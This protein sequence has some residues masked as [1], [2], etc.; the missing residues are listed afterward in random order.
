ML[1]LQPGSQ[2]GELMP[3]AIERSCFDGSPSTSDNGR[4]A[5]GRDRDR[6][7]H[8][9]R[10]NKTKAE[11]RQD[12]LEISRPS[13][14]RRALA[15]GFSFL[16][17]PAAREVCRACLCRMACLLPMCQNHPLSSILSEV[18]KTPMIHTIRIELT[19]EVAG[20]WPGNDAACD[21]ALAHVPSGVI[22]L[23]DHGALLIQSM[24]AEILDVPGDGSS[25][26][27]P[28]S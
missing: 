6:R 25:S 17:P 10:R 18:D 14:G 20:E 26:A 23:G 13:H 12:T 16:L 28:Q 22:D 8:S 5:D 3:A 4:L 11:H 2:L 19:V 9:A 15:L 21:A 24:T 1:A 27:S 7:C